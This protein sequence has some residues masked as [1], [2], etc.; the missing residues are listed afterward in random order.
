MA[1]SPK[2]KKQPRSAERFAREARAL[3]KN[4]KKRK[5]QQEKRQQLKEKLH[6]QD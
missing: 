1:E 4:L 3:Q 6:G 2:N 5:L